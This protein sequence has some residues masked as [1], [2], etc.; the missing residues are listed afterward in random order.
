MSYIFYKFKLNI[1]T[2]KY[3]CVAH[4]TRVAPI[5]SDH[6]KFIDDTT[7]IL[8][9]EDKDTIVISHFEASFILSEFINSTNYL[10]ERILKKLEHIINKEPYEQTNN[11]HFNPS[12]NFF[13]DL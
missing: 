2:N 3:R 9:E 6:V 5:D 12:N 13:N 7:K 10:N 11:Y 4:T 8:M 1:Y